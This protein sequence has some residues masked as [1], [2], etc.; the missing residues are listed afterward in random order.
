MVDEGHPILFRLTKSRFQSMKRRAAL[1]EEWDGHATWR[2]HWTP[3]AKDRR[4][5][6]H[7]PEEAALDVLLHEVPLEN[8]SLSLVTALP[9]SAERA[10]E[11]YARRYDVEHDIRGVKVTLD[12]GNIRAQSVAMVKKELLTSIAAYNLRSRPTIWWCSFAARPRSWPA[13]RR[14]D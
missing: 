12:T 14:G 9:L 4:K 6:P 2:L 3:T 8:D 10:G 5:N 13:F 1:Q 7:L 11:W